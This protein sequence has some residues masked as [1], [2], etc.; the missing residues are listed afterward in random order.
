MLHHRS[1]NEHQ[2]PGMTW[3][4]P[5]FLTF[6]LICN[7][8]GNPAHSQGLMDRHRFHEYS[9]GT[10]GTPGVRI[11]FEY[12]NGF[13]VVELLFQNIL[14]LKFIVD[15][16]AEFTI[17]TRREVSDLL[18]IPYGREYR[19]IGADLRT[20]VSARLIRGIDLGLRSLTL[21]ERDLLVL[22]E[23]QFR[24]D[25]G[26]GMP[27]HGILGADILNR[28]VVTIDYRRKYLTLSD[29][30]HFNIPDGFQAVPVKLIR[31]KPFIPV[32]YQG[33]PDAPSTD[34]NLLMD[35]GASL[36]VLF[37][38]GTHEAIPSL[39]P[40]QEGIVGIGLGGFIFGSRGSAPILELGPFQ[41]RE[42]PSSFQD[43]GAFPD[44]TWLQG[45][46]GIVGNLVLQRF[47]V[48]LDYRRGQLF[49]K[50]EKEF[51]T[52]PPADRSGLFILASGRDM[53]TFVIQDV[54][55]G[56]P[57]KDAGLQAG[58][59]ILG[60]NGIP[61]TFLTLKS[62]NR[63][64]RAQEGKS[65]RLAIRRANARTRAIITLRDFP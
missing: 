63:R 6:F 41:I 42:L 23:D 35:T 17:L 59:I 49:L 28:F 62:L 47:S 57:A 30:D 14:P 45:R 46:H 16:G 44:T 39:P 29:P 27:I 36:T 20:P 64:L 65:V 53:R 50:P 34:L 60:I 1:Q 13:L 48:I 56:S 3:L 54:A 19:L 10:K 40:G 8:V 2:R 22:L 43:I 15:T 4:L 24:L 18:R 5:Q 61:S 31:N 21:R 25:I 37:H 32:A 7:V 38:S 33:T 26:T 12:V 52:P 11:P 55:F 58:D 51:H 9:T